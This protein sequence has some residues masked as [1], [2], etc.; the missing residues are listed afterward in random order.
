MEELLTP[1]EAAAL[2]GVSVRTLE[3]WRYRRT[4]PPW[5]RLGG[6]ARYEPSELR[7]H[8]DRNRHGHRRPA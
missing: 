2:L 3:D 6:Q 5:V 4:G 1:A 7:R 8:L